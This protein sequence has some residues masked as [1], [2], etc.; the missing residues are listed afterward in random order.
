MPKVIANHMSKEDIT[1][2]ILKVMVTAHSFRDVTGIVWPVSL[3]S[4]DHIDPQGD[5]T[6]ANSRIVY[7]GVNLFRTNCPD[8]RFSVEACQLMRSNLAVPVW[9]DNLQWLAEAPMPVVR[10]GFLVSVF[11]D[12]RVF[13]DEWVQSARRVAANICRSLDATQTSDQARLA[14]WEEGQDRVRQTPRPKVMRNELT[15][16]QIAPELLRVMLSPYSF[17]DVTGLEVAISAASVDR[18][19]PRGHHTPQNSRIVFR[20]EAFEYCC[21][22]PPLD[23][24]PLPLRI[25]YQTFSTQRQCTLTRVN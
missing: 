14:A 25:A 24:Y 22:I 6:L 10:D 23:L 20:G 9:Q 16:D 4:V 13:E 15:P 7:R 12:L 18:L 17:R 5:H 8:D 21:S 3:A 2:E 11:N 1:A 19:D